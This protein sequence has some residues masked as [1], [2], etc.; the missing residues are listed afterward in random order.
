MPE[1]VDH[2]LSFSTEGLQV[3]VERTAQLLAEAECALMHAS[4]TPELESMRTG[5]VDL[6]ANLRDA[7]ARSKDL[8]ARG[9]DVSMEMRRRPEAG[10]DE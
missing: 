8:L 2:V 1:R 5:Y 3:R 10:R 7:Y 9:I 4:R 6:V